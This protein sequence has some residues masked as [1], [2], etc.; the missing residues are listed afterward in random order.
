MSITVKIRGTYSFDAL[1][2]RHPIFSY[3]RNH[4]F[5]IK[6][7]FIWKINECE[8]HD[9]AIFFYGKTGYGKSSTIN[10]ITG[11]SMMAT[12]DFQP[13]TKTISS[14]QF[15]IGFSEKEMH[16]SFNDLP[17]IGES[18]ET[19]AEYLK[20]YSRVLPKTAC[21]VYVLRADQRD[22]H[23]D[24][25]VF[26]SLFQQ[27]SHNSRVLIAINFADKIEPI[28]RSQN[29]LPSHE[30]LSNLLKKREIIQ[31]LFKMPS[32][33]IVFYSA[34]TGYN[35]PEF[36]QKIVSILKKNCINT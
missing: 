27:K 28:N 30:Q 10:R 16:L 7:Q 1:V 35:L 18:A 11:T 6:D 17:G 5:Q 29:K 24:L 9:L 13:C 15:K 3:F 2:S 36:T 31:D 33:N 19:D 14:I 22:F 32:S 20:W 23:L 34:D 25:S 4:Q 21:C 8:A 12:H 26:E